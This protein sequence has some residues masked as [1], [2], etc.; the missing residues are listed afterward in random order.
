[1]RNNLFRLAAVLLIVVALLAGWYRWSR[2]YVPAGSMIDPPQ[3]AA[4]ID[5]MDTSGERFLL[6]DLRGETVLLFF[7]YTF[8]PDVCPATLHD[9]RFVFEQLG[10]R[11]D[12]ARIV[13][14][15]VDPA[16]DSPDRIRSYL[17]GFDP[18]FIGLTGTDAALEQVYQ[19]YSVQVVRAPAAGAGGYEVEHI[20]RIFVIDR[21]GRLVATF[22]YGLGREAIL[23][24]LQHLLSTPAQ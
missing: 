9:I 3:P 12:D 4:E 23:A 8:C 22:P 7:G 5:L 6:S 11:T 15:T 1:M 21:A 10:D 13:F 20:S 16:R 18:D 19:D 2:E 14:I 17:D 24:D